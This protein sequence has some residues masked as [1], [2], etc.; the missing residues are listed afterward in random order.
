MA[1]HRWLSR[2]PIVEAVVELSV[3]VRGDARGN[4]LEALPVR[5]AER[6]PRVARR[7]E[8][9]ARGHAES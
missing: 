5:L 7:L 2:A 9:T 8:A 4:A 6:Y 1:T 3:V